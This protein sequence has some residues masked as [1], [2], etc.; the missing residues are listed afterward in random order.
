MPNDLDLGELR[1][2]R[3]PHPS[4]ALRYKFLNVSDLGLDLGFES[5]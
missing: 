1:E 3:G 5:R 4:E 2:V